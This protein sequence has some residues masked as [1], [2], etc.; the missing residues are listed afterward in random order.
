VASRTTQQRAQPRQHFLHMEGL[1]DIVVGACVEPLN[2]VAPTIARRQNQHRHR[3]AVAPPRLQHRDAIALGQA[4]IEDHRVVRF[5]VAEKPSF[6]AIE[7][8]ID[9]VSGAFQGGD[10]LPVEIA[11]VFNNKQAQFDATRLA[12]LGTPTSEIAMYLVWHASRIVTLQDARTHEMIVGGAGAASTPVFYGRIFNQILGL[13]A[14]FVNGYPGQNEILLAMESGE[15]EAM[16]SPFWSSIRTARPSW[17]P[18]HL[19]RVLFQYGQKPHPDLAGVPFGL[20]LLNNEADKILLRAASAPLGLGRPFAAPPGV[21]A[22]RLAA[23]RAAMMATFQDPAFRADCEAQRLDCSD[24]KSGEEI[25]SLTLE[26]G[27]GPRP[28]PEERGIRRLPRFNL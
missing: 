24:P 20:D 5:R 2:L 13:K 4:D 11:I 12:W 22:E 7:G 28:V 17:I 9:S 23:L 14:R 1:A 15:V 21:P 16:T 18:Q 3:A 8:P 25:A 10:D 26:D 27:T 6:L 19:V